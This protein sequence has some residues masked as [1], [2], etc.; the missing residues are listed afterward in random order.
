MGYKNII[1]K[2]NGWN[3]IILVIFRENNAFNST[4]EI[5]NNTMTEIL[6]Y[7]PHLLTSIEMLAPIVP[8]YGNPNGGIKTPNN[9]LKEIKNV[10]R[11]WLKPHLFN[12]K[13][14]VI[15]YRLRI[16]HSN[17]SFLCEGKNQHCG[18]TLKVKYFL[19]PC[20]LSKLAK[21]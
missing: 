16:G 18:E 17:M 20:V 12:R 21:A 6:S 19:D 7:T 15:I 10:I 4:I 11:Y 8:I 5:V 3:E 1:V 2:F 9:K 13:D 14:K